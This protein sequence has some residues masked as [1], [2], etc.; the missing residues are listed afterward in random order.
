MNTTLAESFAEFAGRLSHAGVP[1]Q[2]REAARWHIVDTIGVCIAAADPT[3][4]SGRAANNLAE[5]WSAETGATV[6]GVGTQCRSDKAA[7]IN[8]ALAQAL[9]AV[10]P[11][12]VRRLSC[13][14]HHES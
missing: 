10:C 2:V 8:G 5:K 11:S 3:E 4:D 1:D 13:K 7:L 6:F 9:D 14:Q 12:L